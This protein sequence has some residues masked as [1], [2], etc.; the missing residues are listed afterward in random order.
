MCVPECMY[1]Y[2]L[3]AYRSPSSP[4]FDSKY[5]QCTLVPG[6]PTLSS[7]LQWLLHAWVGMYT[8]LQKHSY[9]SKILLAFLFIYLFC[10]WGMVLVGQGTQVETKE[11]LS[12]IGLL[13][14]HVG[15]GNQTEVIRLGGKYL[16][17]LSHLT[18]SLEAP[19]SKPGMKL[20]SEPLLSG[21]CLSDCA[22]LNTRER[23][24]AYVKSSWWRAPR[25]VWQALK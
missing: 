5:P 6:D 23:N 24:S 4:S 13:L 3:N 17:L 14:L 18:G 20:N 15:S 21:Q 22:T 19:F 1:A 8:C 9:I 10:V 25:N 16:Y 12:R 11:L 7:D 2:V